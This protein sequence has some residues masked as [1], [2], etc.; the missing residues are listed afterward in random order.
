MDD[1]A[2]Q[3]VI[4]LIERN[5]SVADFAVFGDGV[6]P[7]WIATAEKAIG[8]PL[9]ETYKWWLANYGGGEIGGEEVFSVYAAHPEEIGG[10][11]IAHNYRLAVETGGDQDLIPLCHSDIDGLFAFQIGRDIPGNEYPVLSL[12]TGETYADDFLEFIEKRINPF[13]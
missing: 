8:S 10:G 4:D 3:R 5:R 9:P 7:E 1:V 11:D 12:A 6:R 13:I 2:A